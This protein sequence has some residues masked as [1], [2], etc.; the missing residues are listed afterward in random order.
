MTYG[1]E[2]VCLSSAK[3]NLFIMI[4]TIASDYISYVLREGSLT[5]IA[6]ILALSVYSRVRQRLVA[7]ILS[8]K[9]QVWI[10][11]SSHI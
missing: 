10:N 11:D 2:S 9:V 1:F 5:I 3:S 8:G 7:H 4:L 6:D